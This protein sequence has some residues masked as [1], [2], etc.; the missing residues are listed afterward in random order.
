MS[1]RNDLCCV[2]V[3]SR[4]T[5][6]AFIECSR[7]GKHRKEAPLHRF[8]KH[9]L[10]SLRLKK[11]GVSSATPDLGL[12]QRPILAQFPSSNT[13]SGIPFKLRT[14]KSK[15]VAEDLWTLQVY[16]GV[17]CQLSSSQVGRRVR[18]LGSGIGG[19]KRQPRSSNPLGFAVDF[20]YPPELTMSTE[21]SHGRLC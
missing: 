21:L 11:H 12:G 16:D 6:E 1:R 15:T 3:Y 7:G 19:D 18:E 4:S 5:F 17:L 9:K 10:P 20:D 8:R 13:E 2:C 14:R